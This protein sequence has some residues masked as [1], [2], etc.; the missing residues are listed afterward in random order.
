MGGGAILNEKAVTEAGTDYGM[1]PVGTGPFKFKSW[2]KG[3]NIVLERNDQYFGDKPALKE[4]VIRAIPE[5]T[6]RTIELESGGVDIAYT[7]TPQDVSRIEDNPNLE[8]HRM[9]ENS[10]TYVG[11]N[12]EKAPF[13]DVRVRQAVNAAVNTEAV[14]NA[15][16]RGVGQ[17][18]IGVVAP[19][20]RYHNAAMGA[21]EYNV[22]RAKQLLAEAGYPNGFQTSIWTNDK[23][24]RIDMATIVQNQLKQVGIEVEIQVLEWSAF[25]EG[26][27]HKEQ[28]MFMVG[29]V[30]QTP[31][32][33]MAVYGPFHSSMKGNNNF[34]FY[35]SPEVDR[36][37]E[38]G[39][40]AAA[41]SPE[42]EAIYF[43]LQ[44][45]LRE[46]LPWM[47]MNNSEAVIG[48]QKDVR[49][50]ELSPFGYY[51]LYNISFASGEE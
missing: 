30:C 49:G 26:L 11:F 14:V 1:N 45:L 28:D 40:L 5:A 43:E 50:F 27:K 19:G 33:D 51:K 2:A 24:E 42:R 48:V 29:W 44:E 13:N 12:C 16:F 39:R 20:V 36:L 25:L 34:T 21:P 38:A 18:A 22:E 7:I 10:T 3:D 31:D 23:K 9:I 8:L 35:G 46:E 41:N 4:I 17:A 47:V 37:I 15:V 32:P 6:S